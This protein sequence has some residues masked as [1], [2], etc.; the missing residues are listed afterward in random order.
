MAAICG[1]GPSERARG[2]AGCGEASPYAQFFEPFGGG[3]IHGATYC[4]IDDTL[5]IALGDTLC[6]IGHMLTKP[7]T[8][9]ELLSLWES[10][11]ALS[12]EL[13]IPYVSAQMMRRRKSIGVAHW[14]AFRK[15]AKR[16]GVPLSDADMIAMKLQ[17]QR[18]EVAA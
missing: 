12:S 3:P 8:F 16:K 10:P 18:R 11:A 9:E 13:N 14:E 2:L 15:A 6:I 4:V 7:Q 1:F 5:G 17:R